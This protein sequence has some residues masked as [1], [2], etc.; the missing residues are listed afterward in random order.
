MKTI[1]T[2]QSRPG[3]LIAGTSASGNYEGGPKRLASRARAVEHE[4]R[5]DMMAAYL[6][7]WTNGTQNVYYGDTKILLA[8]RP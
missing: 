2:D 3:D 6:L 5:S 4:K 8:Q 1:R 7:K